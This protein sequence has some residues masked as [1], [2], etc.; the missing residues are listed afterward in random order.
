LHKKRSGDLHPDLERQDEAPRPPIGGF[1]I[2]RTSMS[3][4]AILTPAPLRRGSDHHAAV[5]ALQSALAALNYRLAVDGEFGAA[6][7]MAVRQFQDAHHLAVDGV[8]GPATAGAIDAELAGT[9]VAA[10]AVPPAGG[11]K[12]MVV[13]IYHGDDVS[14]FCAAR[15][16]GIRGI[17]HKA[18]E[19]LTITDTFYAERRRAALAAG[20]LW[21]AYHFFRP[22]DVE[23]QVEHFL[24]MAAP[25]DKTLVCLDHEDAR[26]PLIDAIRFLQAI[27]RRLHRKAV[28]YSGFLIKEQLTG[29]A[30][31][32]LAGHRLWLCHYGA[33]PRWPRAWPRYW[34]WQYT[35]DGDGPAPHHVPGITVPE[36]RGI[37]I[38]HYDGTPDQLAA[39]WAA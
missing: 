8:V 25:D 22:G 15:A 30:D 9:A 18:T 12:P 2:E 37:D 14:D 28:L 21:G 16:F 11:I 23:R 10:A 24:A 38:N 7:E 5:R 3:M 13:D 19:G 36:G 29:R 35:G 33:T 31:A 34:L 32:F 4:T 1:F 20:L 26:V 6:T 39:E 17:I 27:E